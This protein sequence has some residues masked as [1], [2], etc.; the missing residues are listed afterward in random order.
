[1]LLLMH[2]GGTAPYLVTL[3]SHSPLGESESEVTWSSWRAEGETQR[4]EAKAPSF[5]EQSGQ[6]R[7]QYY[8]I[9]PANAIIIG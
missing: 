8:T 5:G 1:M 6:A 3:T 9:K 7:P 2:P 4:G